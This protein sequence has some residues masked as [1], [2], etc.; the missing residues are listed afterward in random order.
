MS[1]ATLKTVMYV[2]AAV[3]MSLTYVPQLVAYAGALSFLSGALGG[4]ALLKRPGD[5]KV[6]Q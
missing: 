2:L 1:P 4:G 5:E 6:A 3:L